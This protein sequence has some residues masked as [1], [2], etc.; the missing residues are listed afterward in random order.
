MKQRKQVIV[1]AATSKPEKLDKALLRPGR[2]DSLIQLNLPD[3]QVIQGIIEYKLKGKTIDDIDYASIAKQ[4]TGKSCADVNR[5]CTDVLMNCF[6]RARL[7][8]TSELKI[9]NSD[10]ELGLKQFNTV[11]Q[12]QGMFN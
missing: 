11:N 12:P 10:I 5:F 3:E 6:R 7:E 8:S 1:I 4:F 9:S 2:F